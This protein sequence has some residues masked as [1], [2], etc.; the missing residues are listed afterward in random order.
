MKRS[1]LRAH[2]GDAAGSQGRGALER[3]DEGPKEENRH[4]R[5]RVEGRGQPGGE[6]ARIQ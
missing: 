5:T 4:A 3:K 1:L 2:A 6:R